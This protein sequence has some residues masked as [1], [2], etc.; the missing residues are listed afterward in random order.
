MPST[1]EAGAECVSAH[2]RICAAGRWATS[3]PT[4]TNPPSTTWNAAAW[5]GSA[6]TAGMASLERSLSQSLPQICTESAWCCR[7]PS[8]TRSRIS[9]AKAFAAPPDCGRPSQ[10]PRHAPR[11]WPGA[12]LMA[13]DRR[14]PRHSYETGH[15]PLIHGA[16]VQIPRRAP[17]PET[18]R[19]VQNP[20]FWHGHYLDTIYPRHAG[21]IAP[22]MCGMIVVAGGHHS[23]RWWPS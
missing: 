20:V 16:R 12:L 2:A 4:A 9:D 3:A 11:P 10:R 7:E 21:Q 6:R 1:P 15:Q 14:H 18:S 22:Q 19:R 8:G 5:T 17:G 23:C 13:E